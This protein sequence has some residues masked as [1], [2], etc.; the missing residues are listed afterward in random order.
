MG[1]YP[2]MFS[3]HQRLD[4]GQRV[5]DSFHGADWLSSNG[6]S[7]AMNRREKIHTLGNSHYS[8][9]FMWESIKFEHPSKF[10]TLVLD[11]ELKNMI[12]E[13]LNRFLRRKE[14]YKK[15]GRS[16]KRG[17]LLY[18]PPGFGEA[19]AR[20]CEQINLVIED[21]DCTV[22][23]P[24]L[25]RVSGNKRGGQDTQAFS[26][27]A[28][29]YLGVEGYHRLFRDIKELLEATKVTPAQVAE[30]LTKDEDADVALEGFLS[31]LERKTTKSRK[32]RP[33]RNLRKLRP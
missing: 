21:I 11:L 6:D 25:S 20:H 3:M 15:V 16:W 24:D 1:S 18:G 22:N 23:L 5:T 8:R 32:L 30:E 29:N 31:F 10:E 26:I 33:Q 12:G 4:K 17:C 2:T 19:V 14:F 9:K 7:F 27:L 13:D 28:S